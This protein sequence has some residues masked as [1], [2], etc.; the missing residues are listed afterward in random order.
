MRSL[1]ILIYKEIS[2]VIVKE[3]RK[4]RMIYPVAYPVDIASVHQHAYIPLEQLFDI[5]MR[6]ENSI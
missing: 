2:A 3:K 4:E 1:P 5:V 6:G